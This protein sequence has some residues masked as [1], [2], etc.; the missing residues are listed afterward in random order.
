MNIV[1]FEDSI[2]YAKR[3]GFDT[4]YLWGGEWWYWLKTVHT[5]DSF[6]Q[7]AKQIIQ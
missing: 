5:N 6:W 3:I 7:A 4:I 2:N 1:R